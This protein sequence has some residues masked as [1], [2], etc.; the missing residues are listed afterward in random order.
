MTMIET[1]MGERI[2]VVDMSVFAQ[3]EREEL[4]MTHN[5]I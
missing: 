1:F 2:V 4:I 3:V 5:I